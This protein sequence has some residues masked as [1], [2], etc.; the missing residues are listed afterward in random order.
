MLF[1]EC[2]LIPPA[3]NTAT[4]PSNVLAWPA[5]CGW[6]SS[7]WAAV[8]RCPANLVTTRFRNLKRYIRE[9]CAQGP[10]I[11]GD[12]NSRRLA[13][14]HAGNSVVGKVFR[15]QAASSAA[16]ATQTRHH[17]AATPSGSVS[18][19]RHRALLPHKLAKGTLRLPLPLRN[20]TAKNVTSSSKNDLPL[21]I[22]NRGAAAAK[23]GS[24]PGTWTT[25]SRSAVLDVVHPDA[26]QQTGGWPFAL[27]LDDEQLAIGGERRLVPDFDACEH[28]AAPADAEFSW[29]DWPPEITKHFRFD[30]TYVVRVEATVNDGQAPVTAGLAWLGGFGDLTVS[31]PAPID[32]CRCFLPKGGS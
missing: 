12:E 2:R 21:A 8:I 26:A 29:S 30:H 24:F 13:A 15:A 23:P 31:N 17:R 3:P 1:A 19:L 32:T 10:R 9:R 20:P 6:A 11:A 14:L 22:S 27:A 5:A 18:C 7:G 28:A 16:A 25:I 4:K